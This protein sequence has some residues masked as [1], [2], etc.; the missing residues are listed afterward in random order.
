MYCLKKHHVMGCNPYQLSLRKLLKELLLYSL[1]R[2]NLEVEV[3]V[4]NIDYY[5][6]QDKDTNIAKVLSS[7]YIYE[8]KNQ[9]K[10]CLTTYKFD[11]QLF[12]Y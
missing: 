7:Y 3:M 6:K 9:K 11:S 8:K 12:I 10:I 2:N 5:D 1:Y 4:A